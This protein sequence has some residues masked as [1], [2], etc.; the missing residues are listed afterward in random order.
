MTESTHGNRKLNCSMLQLRSRMVFLHHK[1]QR[2]GLVK[3]GSKSSWALNMSSARITWKKKVTHREHWLL[4]VLLFQ[5]FYLIRK[6]SCRIK[7]LRQRLTIRLRL[8]EYFLGG[9]YHNPN[10]WYRFLEF[11]I[12]DY[13][14]S[15][16]QSTGG[17]DSI[18]DLKV[19]GRNF[20]Y[21]KEERRV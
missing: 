3:T 6:Q 9:K 17:A 20:L 16:T 14:I 8:L 11:K 18:P 12:N 19:T 1:F 15:Q 13:D 7:L 10:S 2:E 21:M 5:W 4:W